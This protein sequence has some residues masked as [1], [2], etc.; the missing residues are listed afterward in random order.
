MTSEQT[1]AA[2]VL[3]NEP[4]PLSLDGPLLTAL[5]QYC[6]EKAT[7]RWEQQNKKLADMYEACANPTAQVN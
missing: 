5:N 3:L 4:L 2:P 1:F 7:N 6:W